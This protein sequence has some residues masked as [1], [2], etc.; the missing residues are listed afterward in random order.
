MSTTELKK[1]LIEEINRTNNKVLLE[2]AY[3]LLELESVDSEAYRM[4]Q[5][6]KSIVG[7]ARE[8]IKSGQFLTNEESEKRT[9]KWLNK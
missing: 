3:R 6:E 5:T 7:E 2:E 1:K 4:T 8:Q 9:D